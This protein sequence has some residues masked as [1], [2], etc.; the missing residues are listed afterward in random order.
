MMPGTQLLGCQNLAFD[1]LAA[2]YLKT[3]PPK[4][5]QPHTVRLPRSGLVLSCVPEALEA[6]LQGS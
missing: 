1:I 4:A 3:K 2:S 6:E 5:A